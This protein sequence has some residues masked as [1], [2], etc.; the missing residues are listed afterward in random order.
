[1]KILKILSILQAIICFIGVIFGIG[2]SI[3]FLKWHWLYLSILWFAIGIGYL[4]LYML[5]PEE[6]DD[7]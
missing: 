4:V 7:R 5:L 3:Y 2:I 6:N 1:M